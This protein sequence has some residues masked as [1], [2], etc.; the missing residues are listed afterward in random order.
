M[1][2]KINVLTQNH[3]FTAVGVTGNLCAF[4]Y[5]YNHRKHKAHSPSPAVRHSEVWRAHR[6]PGGTVGG[7]GT[8][9]GHWKE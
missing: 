8:G 4:T 9:L 7:G 3:N 1:Y 6:V 2:L 5:M